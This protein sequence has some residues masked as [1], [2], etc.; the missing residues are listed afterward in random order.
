M[1]A[2]RGPEGGGVTRIAL[3][4]AQAF[5]LCAEFFRRADE[6][7]DLMAAR[8]RLVDELPAGPAGGTKDE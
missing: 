4:H 7:R 5:A 2:Q 8:E 1:T 6:R 3:P